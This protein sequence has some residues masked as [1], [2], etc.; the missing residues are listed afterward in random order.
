MC[1]SCEDINERANFCEDD[2]ILV[3]GWEQCVD[4]AR[5]MAMAGHG[6]ISL[7]SISMQ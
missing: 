1:V 5:T 6:V 4:D 3:L 2:S 7:L